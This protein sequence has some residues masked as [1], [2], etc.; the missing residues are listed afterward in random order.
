MGRL[1]GLRR[2]PFAGLV[3]KFTF[4]IGA[5]LTMFGLAH[6]LITMPAQQ[7][8]EQQL[9]PRAQ[10]VAETLATI[11]AFGW[12]EEHQRR[13]LDQVVERFLRQDDLLYV[14]ILDR[15]SVV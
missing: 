14:A 15:K 8:A 3:P 11:A 10:A 1:P 9:R 5:L 12:P 4:L 7:D 2:L 13:E 6:A